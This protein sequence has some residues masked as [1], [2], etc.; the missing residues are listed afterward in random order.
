M[1]R[2][3][4][5]IETALQQLLRP[6]SITPTGG[7]PIAYLVYK[8][9]DVMRVRELVES[10][11][12]SKADYY[13][14]SVKLVSMGALID[15]FINNSSYRDMWLSP[16][17]DEPNLYKSIRQELDKSRFLETEL[18]NIQEKASGEHPLIVIK[19]VEMLHPFHMMGTIENRIYNKIRTPM[20]VLYPGETQG[21]ARSFLNIYNQDGNYR[22]IN[23]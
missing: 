14:F 21:T 9:E 13:G 19:E 12:P 10:F 6:S 5:K 7:N 16:I 3:E 18:M 17:V 1:E 15:K 23:V 2:Y 8:P 20:L 4:D 22:S 11:L